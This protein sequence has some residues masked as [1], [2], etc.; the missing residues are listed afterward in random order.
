MAGFVEVAAGLQRLSLL[1]LDLVN[2]YLLG[3]VL[4]D[5]GGRASRRR[6]RRALE[7]R[8]IRALVLTHA[9]F[10]HQGG[11]HAVCR[12]RDIPLWCGAGD[13]AAVETGE[14]SRLYPDRSS[15]MARLGD[16]LSGPGHPVERTLRDGDEVGGF[17]VVETPGHTPGH[18]AFWRERDRALVLGDVLFHRNPLTTRP[19]L[20]EPYEFLVLDPALARASARRLARLGP[21]TVCFGHG[22]PL[23]DTGRFQDFVRSL[24]D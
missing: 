1:P 17:V 12:E 23:H 24:P 13:R 9:H 8:P 18:L 3:D 7:G 22:P 20:A 16:L 11:A 4:L 15:V 5:A 21:R 19:G 2:V 6:L 10:D 14:L